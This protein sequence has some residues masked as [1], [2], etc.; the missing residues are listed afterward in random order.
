MERGAAVSY[1]DQ[2]IR[3][4]TTDPT[5]QEIDDRE[6]TVILDTGAESPN[7]STET[8]AAQR[9]IWDERNKTW[10]RPSGTVKQG[11]RPMFKPFNDDDTCPKCGSSVCTHIWEL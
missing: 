4:M 5:Q 7:E 10:I 2:L 8:D 11:R 6:E 9:G 1:E 3:E